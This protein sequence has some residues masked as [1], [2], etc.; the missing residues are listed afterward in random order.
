MATLTFKSNATLRKLARET[1]KAKR[2]NLGWDYET[3]APQTTTDSGLRL[4]HDDGVYLCNAFTPTNKKSPKANGFVVHANGMNPA[5][6][7]NGWGD[8]CGAVGGD[9]FVE[10]IHLNKDQLQRVSEGGAIKIRISP[11]QFEVIA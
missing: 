11:T 1:L 5:T 2:F 4:V 8:G 7:P 10:F 6:D 3:D 9:D